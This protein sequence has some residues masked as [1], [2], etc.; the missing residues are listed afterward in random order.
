MDPKTRD[1]AIKIM[2]AKVGADPVEYAKNVPGTHFLTVAEAK[3]A[4]KKSHDMMSVYG[5]MELSDKFYLDNAVYKVSQKPSDYLV[6]GV[7]M[8]LK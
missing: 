7:I 1:D 3:T 8:G 2:A 5:S 6:P 4:L